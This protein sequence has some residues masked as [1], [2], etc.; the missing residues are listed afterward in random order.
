[1]ICLMVMKLKKMRMLTY[2]KISVIDKSIWDIANEAKDWGI[3]EQDIK[4]IEKFK[5]SRKKQCRLGGLKDF[6]EI[7]INKKNIAPKNI[8]GEPMNHHIVLIETWKRII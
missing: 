4:K 8:H 6:V 2:E 7:Q 3:K 1:M 5:S